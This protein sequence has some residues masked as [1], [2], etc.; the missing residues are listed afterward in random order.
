MFQ[1]IA[2]VT[3]ALLW[4]LY[5]ADWMRLRLL[6]GP[7]HTFC[8]WFPPV[9]P[10]E[11]ARAEVA[12]AAA[13]ATNEYKRGVAEAK[14]YILQ[15]STGCPTV[16]ERLEWM[17]VEIDRLER[18][19]GERLCPYRNN[20]RNGSVGGHRKAP[21]RYPFYGIDGKRLEGRYDTYTEIYGIVS[22][23]TGRELVE[24]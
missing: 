16:A 18:E 10:L 4:L 15:L 13:N 23:E 22:A 8:L 3:A 14:E 6:V 1:C 12:A 17:K 7:V 5:E 21:G 9:D 24:A 2:V 11:G 20:S 19:F